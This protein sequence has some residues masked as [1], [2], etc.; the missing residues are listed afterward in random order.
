[1]GIPWR[2]HDS[3]RLLD[4]IAE[5]SGVDL[6][7]LVESAETEE[8]VR[9]DNAQLATFALSA[10]VADAVGLRDIELAIGHSLG[11]YS[12]LCFAGILDLAAATTLVVERGRAML[13]ASAVRPGT[14]V[15]V[16]GAEPALLDQVLSNF[17]TL[18]IANQNAPG[19]SVVAG[20]IEE[21]EQLRQQAKELGLRKVIPL[22]VGGAFHSPLMLPARAG[23]QE[24]LERTSFQ[25]GRFPVVAN[26]DARPH[27]GG[28]RWRELLLEQLTGT[29]RFQG[30]IES[31]PPDADD[32]VE[33]G[34]GGVLVGLVK[35]MRPEARLAAL[36]SPEDLIDFQGETR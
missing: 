8:L 29:V 6:R 3:A 13:E 1:M 23:L 28:E 9:T 22:E 14:M 4:E 26:V 31:L 32:F 21:I 7:H 18:V 12:A 16:L 19:Q 17:S 20:A 35:R 34:P 25:T 27:E 36:G 11:E 33:L 15:A 24:A 2:G 30:S 10:V 5:I